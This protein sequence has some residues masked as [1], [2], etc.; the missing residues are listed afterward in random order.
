MQ[1]T[2]N[3]DK[4]KLVTPLISCFSNIALKKLYKISRMTT[5]LFDFRPNENYLRTKKQSLTSREFIPH[6]YPEKYVMRKHL[7]PKI[8]LKY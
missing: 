2:V 5:I 6:N 8:P 7:D 1:L 3:F 4:F